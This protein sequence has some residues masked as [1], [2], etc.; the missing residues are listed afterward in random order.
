MERYD[1]AVI[2]TG[3]AGLSAAIT[4]TIRNKKVLLL[5][6]RDLSLKL[7]KAHEIQ[8]YLGFPAVKG[9][10]LAAA[11]QNHLKQ[12][13]IEITEKRINAVYSMG[14]YFALQAGDEMLEASAVILATGVVQG[15]PLPGEEE[16]LGWGVSYCATCDAPLYRGKVAAV[17]GYSP[18]EEAE[19]AFLSEVC[20][21][22]L[23]FPTYKEE[24]HLP[25]A[26]RVIRE[27]V[28]A[29]ENQDGHRIVRT[30]ENEYSVDGVFVLREAVSPG[31]L[32]P[33]LPTEGPHVTVNRNMEAGIPGVF[34]CGDIVGTPYQYIKAAGEGNVAALSAVSYLDQKKRL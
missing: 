34:A 24:T 5:G 32:V 17:V 4:A 22:V 20:R 15:K 19:A 18:R 3:P 6:S 23:Y 14:D 2:G 10:D 7:G 25:E 29:L 12:M 30:A 28:V 31:Q 21:E 13:K 1:I 27:K 26:V 8:N 9:E 33:G 11:F 16:M